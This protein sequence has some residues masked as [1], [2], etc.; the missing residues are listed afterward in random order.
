MNTY[1]WKLW[2]VAGILKKM[3]SLS[4]LGSKV[5][6]FVATQTIWRSYADHMAT[7]EFHAA[8]E[9]LLSTAAK[10]RTA[11]MCAEKFFWKCHRR[12]LSDYLVTQG[13]EV[14]HIVE[15]GRTLCHKLTPYA[16]TAEDGIIYPSPEPDGIQNSFWGLDA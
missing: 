11:V 8:I 10:S 16:V 3:A 5:L 2:E 6:V 4:I 14:V 12:L 15:Q 7:D 13:V 9:K 1:G